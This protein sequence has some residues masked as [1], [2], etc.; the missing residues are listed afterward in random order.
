MG[1]IIKIAKGIVGAAL[2]IIASITETVWDKIVAPIMEEIV[3][4]FGIEDELVI[5]VS[6]ISTKLYGQNVEKA[7]KNAIVKA[8]LGKARDPSDTNSYFDHYWY[9][10]NQTKVTLTTYYGHGV[11]QYIHGIPDAT[12]HGTSIDESA[13]Q[14]ATYAAFGSNATVFNVTTTYPSALVYF[15]N[16]LQAAPYYYHPA[17]DKLT[18]TETI[19]GLVYDDWS[20]SKVFY[21][22]G[23][24]HYEITIARQVAIAEFWITGDA[25]V[26]EGDTSHYTIH[27]TRIIPAGS[28]LTI[29]LVYG[30]AAPSIDY[31]EV[32]SVSMLEGDNEVSFFINTNDNVA[33]D[34]SR[35][36]S[37]AIGVI[38]NSGNIFQSV[39]AIIPSIV[40]TLIHDEDSPTLIVEDRSISEQIGD[41]NVSVGVKLVNT[42]G[43]GF[44][45]DYE[46]V[47]GTATA[48]ADY[49]TTSGTLTFVGTL[50]EVQ[51]I[52]IT[53]TSDLVDDS[54]E[55]F[56]IVL[57][58]C[59]NPS[60]DI[61][62]QGI[63][64]ITDDSAENPESATASVE[65][66]FIEPDFVRE[67][68]MVVKYY[69]SS[70][71]PTA[72][73]WHYW[74]Y[75]LSLELYDGLDPISDTSTNF[76]LF[77][78]AILRKNNANV[79]DYGTTAEIFSTDRLLKKLNLNLD[80]LVDNLNESPD[81]DKIKDAYINIGIN[82]L[83]TGNE[84]SKL[85]YH[86]FYPVVVES[87][88]VSNQNKFFLT[89]AQ[90]DINNA[91]A[92]SDQ[93]FLPSVAGVIGPS[94]SFD[95]VVTETS[96]VV[97]K[98]INATQ[99][100][101]IS[102]DTLNG[103]ATID[104]QGHHEMAANVLGDDNF[105]LPVS[106]YGLNQLS[107]VEQM[108]VYHK[109]I[110]MDVYA[111]QETEVAWYETEEFMILFQVVLIVITIATAGAAAPLTAGAATATT[112]GA[113]STILAISQQIA[114]NYLIS[115]VVSE[116]A[117]ATGNEAL[118]AIV[119]VVAAIAFAPTGTNLSGLSSMVDAK[120]MLNLSID[121]AENLSDAFAVT[122]KIEAKELSEEIS[123]F[124]DLAEKRLEE[125][126]EAA[127]KP[128]VDSDFLAMIRSV[129]AQYAP[130]IVGIYEFNTFYDYDR[131]VGNY[132]KNLLQIGIV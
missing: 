58:N 124:N 27:S 98:Q 107:A 99:Y 13:V 4:I 45:V 54:G 6:K 130:A 105:T 33:V 73:N 3:G 87:P 61:S 46:T 109:L 22:V 55:T 23:F 84:I 43:S 127:Y 57:S 14:A 77:P 91:V 49:N 131:I 18:Y 89:V 41:V 100:D 51:G 83:D 5:Q 129:D 60:V 47:A 70:T 10:V 66:M 7:S 37:V 17:V 39:A 15:K 111:V 85:L 114:I 88:V 34:G 95:H 69:D 112:V 123:E 121:F 62:S 8:V 122:G 92:W 113:T 32:N 11:S 106:W 90:G 79:T 56:N 44:T 72:L 63:I 21:D 128:A 36:F 31:I 76:E 110:R 12:I 26:L 86:L 78:L 74:L 115:Q 104:Y 67:Y 117:K 94:G 93:A 81:L 2:D 125:F 35:E 29:N 48:G 126:S 71:D 132:H 119:G 68:N 30:G 80:E 38:D 1:G 42:P 19:S 116:I 25:N 108:D 82:P 40:T 75:D 20:I 118:A 101:E 24:A 52:D 120:T 103:M 97:R 53:I 96:L 102:I 64:T 50:N 16:L 59:S 9:Q 65:E 28:P